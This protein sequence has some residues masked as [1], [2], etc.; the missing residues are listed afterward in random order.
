MKTI[1]LALDF[2]DVTPKLVT[3][4]IEYANVF[5][6]EIY[7]IHTETPSQY[8]FQPEMSGVVFSHFIS[9]NKN[10][11]LNALQLIEKQIASENIKVTS[12]LLEGNPADTILETAKE[13]NTDLIIIGTHEHGAFCHILFGSTR[14]SVIKQTKCPVL[15][16]P[17]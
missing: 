16:V 15:V 5:N 11:D 8:T 14:E 7:I 13:K 6:A 3:K 2:S 9:A 17:I 4:A 12:I 10:S 1:L